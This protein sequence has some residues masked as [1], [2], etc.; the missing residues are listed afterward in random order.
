MIYELIKPLPESGS[1]IIDQGSPESISLI[2]EL[3]KM[4]FKILDWNKP[5]KKTSSSFHYNCLRWSN[6]YNSLGPHNSSAL[7][8]SYSW[9]HRWTVEVTM[10]TLGSRTLKAPI[11]QNDNTDDLDF[12]SHF[13]LKHQYRGHKLKRFGI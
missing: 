2:Y 3:E 4:G 11:V 8:K 12:H 6:G 1:M 10:P 9:I 13:Q 5:D 7:Y